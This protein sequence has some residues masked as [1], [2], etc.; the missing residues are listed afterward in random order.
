MIPATIRVALESDIPEIERLLSQLDSHHVALLPQVF[1]KPEEPVRPV[2]LL[3]GAIRDDDQDL[4][5]AEGAEHLVGLA[6]VK[7]AKRPRAPMFRARTYAVLENMIVECSR[8]GEGIG[9]AL[10]EG[11]K[12]WA[13][14]RGLKHMQTVCWTANEEA[15]SFYQRLGFQTMTERLECEL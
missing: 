12:S 10:F 3:A 11:V 4:L 14:D 13:L 5:V 8:R 1:H 9:V 6:Q 7:L 2:G 15:L